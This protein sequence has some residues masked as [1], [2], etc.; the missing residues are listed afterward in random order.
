MHDIF[1]I[2]FGLNIVEGNITESGQA[3]LSER[4]I[5]DRITSKG[6]E[7]NLVC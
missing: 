5:G 4:A 6:C 7:T 3:D 2:Q 1:L